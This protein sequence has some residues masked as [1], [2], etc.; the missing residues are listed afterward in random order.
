[1][2]KLLQ[3]HSLS[4][5]LCRTFGGQAVDAF[6]SSANAPRLY[7]DATQARFDCYNYCWP[8]MDSPGYSGFHF[9]EAIGNANFGR[10]FCL[11]DNNSIPSDR[12]ADSV[13]V[14]G[15]SGSG[16]VTGNGHNSFKCY[17]NRLYP[18]PPPTFPP[19]APPTPPPTPPPTAPPAPPPTHPPVSIAQP[20]FAF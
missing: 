15:G 7:T 12:P 18:T 11:F 8:Y 5:G 20:V 9:A 6:A 14:T 4:T 3:S 10:C 13:S 17:S 19:T 2:I 1:M 16:Q